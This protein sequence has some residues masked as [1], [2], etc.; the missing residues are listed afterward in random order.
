[1]GTLRKFRRSIKKSTLRFDPTMYNN[2]LGS[3][4]IT[5]YILRTLDGEAVDINKIRTTWRK[6]S[7]KKSLDFWLD[8]KDFIPKVLSMFDMKPYYNEF[9]YIQSEYNVLFLPYVDCQVIPI[10]EDGIF[11]FTARTGKIYLVKEETKDE[12]E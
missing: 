12:I 4:V 8:D 6:L 10:R 2:V 3:L 1:M 11:P 9:C 7:K 5:H